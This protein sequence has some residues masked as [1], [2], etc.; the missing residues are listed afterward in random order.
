MPETPRVA[1]PKPSEQL[2]WL[3]KN[4]VVGVKVSYCM[5]SEDTAETNVALTADGGE[6]K[7][8]R[9]ERIKKDCEVEIDHFS[10]IRLNRV[11]AQAV[12]AWLDWEKE[13]AQDLAELARLTKKLGA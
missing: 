9:W 6:K 5:T 13:N 8:W 1:P 10:I 4:P 11:A 7:T 12:K 3:Y 2:L